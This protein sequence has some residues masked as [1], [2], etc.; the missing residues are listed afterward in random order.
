MELQKDNDP[1][2]ELVY[3][4]LTDFDT[5][6]VKEQVLEQNIEYL[7]KTIISLEALCVKAKTESQTAGTSR[8][9][10]AARDTEKSAA[11]LIN[12]IKFAI[13]FMLYG[14]EENLNDNNIS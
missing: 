11:G 10:A 2:V 6:I 5:N 1:N 7:E 12:G 9:R 8:A 13:S 14:K 4:W 3:K